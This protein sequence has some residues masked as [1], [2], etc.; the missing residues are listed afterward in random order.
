M[1]EILLMGLKCRYKLSCQVRSDPVITFFPL[2][3][4]ETYHSYISFLHI[5]LTYHSYISIHWSIKILQLVCFISR[6]LFTHN[7]L[8]KCNPRENNSLS[9][10]C[11]HPRN[12][13]WRVKEFDLIQEWVLMNLKGRVIKTFL[14]TKTMLFCVTKPTETCLWWSSRVCP[15]QQH[16]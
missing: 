1:Q 8:L 11:R 16:K 10:R 2:T 3:S 12:S 13:I 5:I 9:C 4:L 7:S 14:E 15:Y 6:P